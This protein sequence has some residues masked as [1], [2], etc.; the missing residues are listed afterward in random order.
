MNKE[1]VLVTAI[2]GD[3]GNSILKCLAGSFRLI[4]CDIGNYP[5]GLDRVD[6]FQKVPY[7]SLGEEY[8]IALKNIIK[9]QNVTHLIPVNE[10]EIKLISRNRI[11]LEEL[12]VKIII[13]RQDVLDLCFDKYILA[14]NLMEAGLNAPESFCPENF[15]EDGNEYLIKLRFSS[16]SKMIRRFKTSR[17]MNEII[18]DEL[19][20]VVIQR[21]IPSDESEYTIGV[22]SD[23]KSV[24]T[25]IFKRKLKNG[26]SNFVELVN[27]EA[28]KETA[29]K[30]A[31]F[32]K[33]NGSIN[34]QLRRYQNKDY[35]FE[36]NPRLSG[37]VYFRHQLGYTDALWWISFSNGKPVEPYSQFYNKALGIR[38][39]NEKFL[40]LE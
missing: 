39:T 13:Q 37:T 36:I 9:S 28:M 40:V 20:P 35:I 7:A 34:I 27:D 24:R 21:Y 30:T 11:R 32:F 1:T 16:G 38:E 17:E 4:G 14:L 22:F 12:G 23:G 18:K 26:Y 33:L 31:E 5:A 2:S 19:R 8:L 15:I 10:E 6:Y 25:I 3:V 29:I